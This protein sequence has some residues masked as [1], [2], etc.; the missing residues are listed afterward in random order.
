MAEIDELS[1]EEKGSLT[2]YVISTDELETDLLYENEMNEFENLSKLT[3]IKSLYF[4]LV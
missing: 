2:H 4:K 1:E 3:N